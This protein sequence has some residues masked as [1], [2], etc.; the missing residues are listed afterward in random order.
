M[1][2]FTNEI[3]EFESDEEAKKAG[4]TV[5]L[6]KEQAS[7]LNP[8]NRKQRRDWLKQQRKSGYMPSPKGKK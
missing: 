5:P 8:M 7:Q 4:F 1:N 3:K 2:P 6:T